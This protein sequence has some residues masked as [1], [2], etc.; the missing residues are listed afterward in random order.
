[1]MISRMITPNKM[2]KPIIMIINTDEEIIEDIEK[3]N[4]VVPKI[5]S[6]TRRAKKRKA[7]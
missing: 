7:K 2:I 6:R 4:N 5:S 1:M 3:D